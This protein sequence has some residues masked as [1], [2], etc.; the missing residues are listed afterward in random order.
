MPNDEAIEHPTSQRTFVE[1]LLKLIEMRGEER[2]LSED[3]EGACIST[4]LLREAVR[5]RWYGKYSI[6]TNHGVPAKV[7]LLERITER[8]NVE[9]RME[10]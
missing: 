9:L 1:V 7:K 10:S 5:P 8:L 6:S 2:V 4:T 3:K